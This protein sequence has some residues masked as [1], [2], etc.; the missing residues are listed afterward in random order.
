[1][2]VCGWIT[3]ENYPH[4]KNNAIIK[5]DKMIKKS[6]MERSQEK[7]LNKKGWKEMSPISTKKHFLSIYNLI[8]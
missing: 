2:Y 5:K 4:G 7:G 6:W 1:M 8:P 3:S